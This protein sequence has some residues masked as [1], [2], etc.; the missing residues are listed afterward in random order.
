MSRPQRTRTDF[1]IAGFP[2]VGGWPGTMM[3]PKGQEYE[4]VQ[5][6]GGGFRWSLANPNIITLSKS[7]NTMLK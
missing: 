4:S 7:K 5:P 3:K 1:P 2:G 6:T